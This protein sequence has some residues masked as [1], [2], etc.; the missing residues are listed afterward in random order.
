[1]EIGHRRT[2]ACMP[3]T[4][5]STPEEVLHCLQLVWRRRN[6]ENFAHAVHRSSGRTDGSKNFPKLDYTVDVV[7]QSSQDSQCAP[8]SSNCYGAWRYRVAR[9]RLSSSLA[10]LAPL[11][12]STWRHCISYSCREPV[13]KW[14][15]VNFQ[16]DE[17]L[18][19]SLPGSCITRTYPSVSEEQICNSLVTRPLLFNSY[20]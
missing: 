11:H 3:R 13:T 8:R 5:K 19:S 1:M 18:S 9:E 6:Y 4:W 17:F 7:R 12:S 2:T 20:T 14:T 16:Q 10:W 15:F